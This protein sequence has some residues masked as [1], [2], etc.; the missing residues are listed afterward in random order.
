VINLV[1]VDFINGKELACVPF[2]GTSARNFLI[3]FH[4]LSR[5]AGDLPLMGAKSSGLEHP[6]HVV[7]TTVVN[8]DAPL[9][10]LLKLSFRGAVSNAID[11]S[12]EPDDL[13]LAID[14]ALEELDTI[15]QG[16]IA[17]VVVDL[18]TEVLK[19]IGIKFKDSGVG[20]NVEALLD[21]PKHLLVLGSSANAFDLPDGES[22]A[23]QNAVELVA[24]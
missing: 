16:G 19:K 15:Q 12:L 20:R 6:C 9:S 2:N 23:A 21:V 7:V 10:R 4:S 5:M 17:V 13:A 24:S 3:T 14:L 11:S 1:T 8:G 22:C 18:H